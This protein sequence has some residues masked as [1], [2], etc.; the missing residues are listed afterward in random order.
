MCL[1][2]ADYMGVARSEM[3]VSPVRMSAPGTPSRCTQS[4]VSTAD[5]D[6]QVI[7]FAGHG[8]CPRIAADLAVLNVAAA[9]IEFD[10]D[11]D[12]LAAVRARYEL[13]VV[14]LHEKQF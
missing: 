14:G 6:E 12:C 1:M 9:E 13:G 8:D 11:L 3:R 4:L 5:V 2:R 10:V 7:A